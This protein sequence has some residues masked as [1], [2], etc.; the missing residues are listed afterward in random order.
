MNPVEIAYR[1]T[2]RMPALR[3][4]K[5]MLGLYGGY[6]APLIG[7]VRPQMLQL[8]DDRCVVRVPL[9]WFNKNRMFNGMY[10]GVYGIGADIVGGALVQHWIRNQDVPMSMIVARIEQDLV[11]RGD[12]DV[13][14][15]SEDSRRIGDM[16]A[17]AA[18]SGTR[19]QEVITVTATTRTKGDEQTVARMKITMSVK[20]KD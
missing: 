2:R 11:R 5:L 1:M 20:P 8:D 12:S 9:N 19:E 10:V 17:R 14:F 15:T 7:R 18:S 4:A 13:L 3:R 16:V 6:V